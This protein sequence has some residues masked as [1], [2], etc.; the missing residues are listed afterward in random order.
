MAITFALFLIDSERIQL[1]SHMANRPPGPEGN[2]V[3]AE[4]G[5]A[6]MMTDKARPSP[7]VEEVA[8]AAL[9][10]AAPS[11]SLLP[12]AQKRWQRVSTS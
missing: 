11:A 1:Q 8:H 9:N 5:A 10:G 12:D 7:P 6:F 4:G 3:L 2:A